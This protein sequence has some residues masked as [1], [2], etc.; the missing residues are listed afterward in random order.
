MGSCLCSG[1][2]TDSSSPNQQRSRRKQSRLAAEVMQR[3]ED[4]LFE[5]LL[6]E[7]GEDHQLQ[8]EP[9]TGTGN[10]HAV[11][12]VKRSPRLDP[13]NISQPQNVPRLDLSQMMMN[14][15]LVGSV[16]YT[17]Q[18]PPPPPLS[19]PPTACSPLPPLS[20]SSM[21][22]ARTPDN[23]I[24]LRDT[25][26]I[27]SNTSNSNQAPLSLLSPTGADMRSSLYYTPI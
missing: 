17:P 14:N 16:N 23:D 27:N 11:A 21:L 8:Y 4:F 2:Y 20:P 24:S 10:K 3:N 7:Y 19:L 15:S 25:F 6:S 5:K 26:A 18:T 22:A 12:V 13:W 9:T 1:C